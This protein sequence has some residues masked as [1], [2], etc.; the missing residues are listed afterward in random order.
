ML[1][2]GGQGAQY[3]SGEDMGTP[4]L[5]QDFRTNSARVFVGISVVNK[6]AESRE[7]NGHMAVPSD[8]G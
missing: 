1:L 6:A 2:S 5:T 4:T 3:L 8:V 7:D